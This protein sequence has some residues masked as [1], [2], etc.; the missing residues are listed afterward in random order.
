MNETQELVCFA[1]RSRESERTIGWEPQEFQCNNKDE[2]RQDWIVLTVNPCSLERKGFCYCQKRLQ[3]LVS[4]FVEVLVCTH[5]S[6]E[7]WDVTRCIIHACGTWGTYRFCHIWWCTSCV[8]NHHSPHTPLFNEFFGWCTSGRQCLIPPLTPLYYWFFWMMHFW[9]AMPHSTSYPF[10][11]WC[12][13]MMH[14][15]C[16][17]FGKPG[18]VANLL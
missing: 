13:W 14:L 2:N 7:R 3:S 4:L 6:E 9:A 1:V 11:Y 10:Y 17:T 8:T 16:Q 15:L 18:L 5:P 12:F